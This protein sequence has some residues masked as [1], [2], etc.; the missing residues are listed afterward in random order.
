MNKGKIEPSE[1]PEEIQIIKRSRCG[2]VM[3][4]SPIEG[5]PHQHWTNVREILFEVIKSADFD[6]AMVSDADEIG[7]IQ[8]RIVQ[9]LYHC[10]MIVCDVSGKNANVMFELGM[11]LAFNR[12]AI[13]IKDDITSYSFDTGLI[14]HIEYPA[15]LRYNQIIEFKTILRSRI[16][17]TYKASQETDHST[18]LQNFGEFT[19]AKIDKKEIT[20]QDF[21]A[22]ELADLRENMRNISSSIANLDRRHENM[23]RGVLAPNYATVNELANIH[24]AANEKLSLQFSDE[25]VKI[26]M[27]SPKNTQKIPKEIRNIE[28]K[29]PEISEE[30]SQILVQKILKLP[31]VIGADVHT[32]D[33]SP[34]AK[35]LVVKVMAFDE[36]SPLL[37]ANL[38]SRIEDHI[39]RARVQ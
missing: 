3:P 27:S 38:R 11:R 15:D 25:V 32:A 35:K 39:L 36:L 1:V 10:D 26:A 2:V 37:I 21:I 7:V 22:K 28:F 4:I 6:V 16:V 20:A 29:L 31:E 30:K 9:N 13:I 8:R 33:S 19:V 5:Y 17:A 14:E 34:N 23:G 18:F 12:P 24:R